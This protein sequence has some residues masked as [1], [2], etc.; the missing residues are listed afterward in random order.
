MQMRFNK[1]FF[2]TAKEGMPGDKSVVSSLE[3]LD[4]YVVC[5]IISFFKYIKWLMERAFQ[6]SAA[7]GVRVEENN[8]IRVRKPLKQKSNCFLIERWKEP[9]SFTSWR[10]T[11]KVFF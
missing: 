10:N 3:M 2:S 11:Q 9:K 7:Y 4:K 5:K 8:L 6:S 1:S